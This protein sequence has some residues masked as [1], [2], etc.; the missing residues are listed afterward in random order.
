MQSLSQN[1]DRERRRLCRYRALL[2]SAQRQS[3]PDGRSG[4]APLRI[5][6]EIRGRKSHWSAPRVQTRL[7]SFRPV[8]CALGSTR[9]LFRAT[10]SSKAGR[11]RMFRQGVLLAFLM[12]LTGMLAAAQ[13]SAPVVTMSVTLPEGRTQEVT[14]AESGLGVGF[15]QEGTLAF[16]NLSPLTCPVVR[17]RVTRRQGALSSRHL[18]TLSPPWLV[19]GEPAGARRR[20]KGRAVTR[21]CRRAPPRDPRQDVGLMASAPCA[22]G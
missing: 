18:S 11:A 3:A 1:R 8:T 4:A 20:S 13:S 15:Q 22:P 17:A 19:A 21:A 5:E 9:V 6:H 10:N 14:A 16:Q 2:Y 7:T 12:M